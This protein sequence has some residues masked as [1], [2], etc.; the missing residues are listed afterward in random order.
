[1]HLMYRIYAYD[2]KKDNIII[3][4]LLYYLGKSF[5]ELGKTEKIYN[6]K[7]LKVFEIFFQRLHQNKNFEK[8]VDEILSICKD[9]LKNSKDNNEKAQAIYCI[10]IFY[11][12]KKEYKRTYCH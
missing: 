10:G 2:R 9:F 5:Y 11:Y 4:L 7:A 6:K 12:R 1:M 8:E 3:F